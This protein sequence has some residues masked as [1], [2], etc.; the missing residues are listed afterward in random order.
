M[1]RRGERH[2]PLAVFN[3]RGLGDGDTVARA[4]RRSRPWRRDGR[5]RASTSPTRTLAPMVARGTPLLAVAGLILALVLSVAALLRPPVMVPQPRASGS[6]L[7]LPQASAAAGWATLFVYAWL[8]AGEGTATSLSRFTGQDQDLS[9]VTPGGQWAAHVWP[10]TVAPNGRRE[11]AV[12]VA[13]ITQWQHGRQV[14]GG[15]LHYYRLGV[16]VAGSGD[17]VRWSVAAAPAEVAAPAAAAGVALGYDQTDAATT[18]PL[19][20]TVTAFLTGYLTGRGEDLARYTT[21]GHSIAPVTPAT[22]RTIR[23]DQLARTALPNE[24]TADT[25][26]PA[27]GTRVHVL[28]TIATTNP[29]GLHQRLAYPL[30]LTARAGRW[31]VTAVEPAPV[32]DP[33]QPNAQPAATSSAPTVSTPPTHS[34]PG[35]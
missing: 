11:W 18:G 24:Q 2:D 13:A 4:G 35:D 22:A 33:T 8:Q 17:S 30:L 31:E 6:G 26:V 9:G 21:P 25:A 16:Q 19:A 27:G 23:L 32:L 5:P 14:L 15:G 12:T 29:A 28:A 3:D 34:T 20:D 7:Q 1:I 10:V